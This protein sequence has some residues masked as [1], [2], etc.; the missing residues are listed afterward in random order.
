[1]IKIDIFPEKPITVFVRIKGN[2]GTRELRAIIDTGSQ[3]CLVPMIDA[4]KIGY[5]DA[6]FVASGEPGSGTLMATQG[7]LIET[8]EIVLKEV[9]I[10]NLIAKDV[11]ALCFDLPRPS[12]LEAVLGLSFLKNFKTTIDYQKGLLTLASL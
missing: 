8:S 1:M 3:Y 7:C 5:D 9:S 11:K 12:G 10:G 4:L 6:Y 2:R